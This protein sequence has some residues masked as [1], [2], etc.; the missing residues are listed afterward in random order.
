MIASANEPSLEGKTQTLNEAKLSLPP[1]L[2]FEAVAGAREESGTS[3]MTIGSAA[4][5][6]AE[7]LP[8]SRKAR[9]LKAQ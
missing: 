1:G 4:E 9:L 3:A 6:S 5:S 2:K 7:K 8:E